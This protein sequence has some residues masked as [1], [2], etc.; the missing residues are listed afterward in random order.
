M[1]FAMEDARMNKYDF[2]SLLLSEGDAMVCLDA[3]R[4]DVS[5]PKKHKD[6]PSLNLIFNLNF[7]RPIEFNEEEILVT[8][9]F[10]GRPHKCVIP[11]DSIWAIYEPSMKKGQVWEECL[12]DDVD[13]AE[14][15]LNNGSIESG[16]KPALT[17]KPGG[18]VDKPEPPAKR[19]RS[20]LRVIK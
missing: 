13:F 19:D 7:R 20:H 14:Q 3:R 18:R 12:P 6:D 2:L 8:L 9:S 5:V 1:L 16:K 4:D 11:L 10:D 15:I 17:Y